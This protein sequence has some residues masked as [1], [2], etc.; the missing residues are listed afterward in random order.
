MPSTC[1]AYAVPRAHGDP[2]CVCGYPS[3]DRTTDHACC[4]GECCAAGSCAAAIAGWRS[5]FRDE[6]RRGDSYA[7][8][9]SS[10]V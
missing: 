1:E 10:Y 8:G 6:W 7:W 3:G 9:S 2:G 4:A 5:A